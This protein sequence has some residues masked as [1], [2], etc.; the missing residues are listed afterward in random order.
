MS[1]TSIAGNSL[2]DSKVELFYNDDCGFICEGKTY[3]TAITADANGNR[4]YIG[5]NCTNIVATATDTYGATSEFSQA[6]IGESDVQ[7]TNSTCGKANASITGIRVVSGTIRQYEFFDYKANEALHVSDNEERMLVGIMQHMMNEAR[8]CVDNYSQTILG[9]QLELLLS[10]AER[11]YQRQFL[12][13]KVSSHEIISRLE[14]LL[15]KYCKSDK[16]QQEGIP[17]V[18]YFSD[19]LHL[20]A[21]YLSRLL[22]TLTGLSTK[23]YIQE[24]IIELAKEKLST[25]E[26]TINEIAYELG[27]EHP[28]SLSKLFKTK[29]NSSPKAFRQSFN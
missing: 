14:E 16:L 24:K 20:S 5:S 1:A 28:Q 17:A 3:I 18:T 22:K 26:L 8:T 23:Q 19:A 2:P 12:T 6:L 13:R 7:V 15:N 11:F 25:T 21:N 27:F 9:A 10:Y 29:T 4:S